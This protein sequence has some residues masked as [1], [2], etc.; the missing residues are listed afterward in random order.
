MHIS[1]ITN[2]TVMYNITDITDTIDRMIYF[3][4]VTNDQNIDEDI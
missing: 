2:F 1:I 4:V 3:F